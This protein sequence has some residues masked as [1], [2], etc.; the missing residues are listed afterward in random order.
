MERFILIIE[1]VSIKV[2]QTHFA[3]TMCKDAHHLVLYQVHNLI[4]NDLLA[5]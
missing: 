4:L 5:R 2:P 3:T 1:G